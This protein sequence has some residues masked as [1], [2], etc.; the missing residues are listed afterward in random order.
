VETPGCDEPDLAERRAA[1]IFDLTRRAANAARRVCVLPVLTWSPNSYRHSQMS[2]SAVATTENWTPLWI[3]ETPF[4]Y[5]V[6]GKQ[7]L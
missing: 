6:D 7:L 1:S 2:G 3:T 5:H 4:L